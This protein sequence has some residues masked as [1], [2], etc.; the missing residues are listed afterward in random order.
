M[1]DVIALGVGA[2]KAG[3]K[4]NANGRGHQLTSCGTQAALI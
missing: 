2:L 3:V 4:S 1:S